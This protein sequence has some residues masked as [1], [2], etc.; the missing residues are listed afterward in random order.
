MP[1][2]QFG[3]GRKV[4]QANVNFAETDRPSRIVL[5]HFEVA[6]ELQRYNTKHDSVLEV[7]V[8]FVRD[9][10]PG[11]FE[12]IADLPELPYN[13]PPAITSTDLL[14]D[15]VIWSHMEPDTAISYPSITDCLLQDKLHS[16]T[17][18]KVKQVPG[19]GWHRGG[20]WVHNGSDHP[21]S[22]KPGLSAPPGV[23][24]S[25]SIV[26]KVSPQRH[27]EPFKTVCRVA[28]LQSQRIWTTRNSIT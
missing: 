28:I 5:N 11:S 6:L 9:H 10:L 25:F 3:G 19:P 18:P 26:V 21:R 2:S 7:I 24:S 17:N 12:I 14:P 20:Q 23:Q 1:T 15:I 16:G 13:F 27:V 4:C 8:D 22:W